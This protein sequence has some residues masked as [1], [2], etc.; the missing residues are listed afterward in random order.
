MK[1]KKKKRSRRSQNRKSQ[2][3]LAIDLRELEHN[4]PQGRITDHRINLTLQK[5]EEFL[6]REI[7][8][9]MNEQLRLKIK[10]LKLKELN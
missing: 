10:T 4:F 5:L 9:E 1:Q 8:E 7:H 6:K 3:G 2:I